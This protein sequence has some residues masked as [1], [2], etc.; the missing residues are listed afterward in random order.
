MRFVITI[1]GILALCVSCAGAEIKLRKSYTPHGLAPVL[2]AIKANIDQLNS[3]Y[4]YPAGCHVRTKPLT[5]TSR[6]GLTLTGP[7]GGLMDPRGWCRAWWPK[8]PDTRCIVLF[9]I[10][11]GVPCI[12]FKGCR[13]LT[14]SGINFCRTTPGPLFQDERQEGQNSGEIRFVRCGFYRRGDAGNAIKDPF[15]GKGFDAPKEGYHALSV[16]GS[17]GADNYHF[18]DCDFHGLDR[19]LDIDCPQTTRVTF[20]ACNFRQC[21]NLAWCRKSGNLSFY[22]CQSYDTGPAVFERCSIATCTMLWSGGWLDWS[23]GQKPRTLADFSRTD[24]GHFTYVGGNGKQWRTA[25]NQEP[26]EPLVVPSRRLDRFTANILGPAPWGME[27]C[28]GRSN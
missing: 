2:Q 12:H 28:N 9:D 27:V 22:G 24:Y 6:H 20:T 8:N 5:Y 3:P 4:D 1:A 25:S 16:R 18:R 21:N 11:A 15:D 10:P 23:S 26:C 13:A 7:S 19:C 17:N 14:I